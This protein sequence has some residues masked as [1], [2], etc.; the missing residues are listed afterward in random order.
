MNSSFKFD[1]LKA[2]FNSSF[3]SNCLGV[4]IF[5]GVRLPNFLAFLL[6][7]GDL[8]DDLADV[9]FDL[10]CLLKKS[11]KQSLTLVASESFFF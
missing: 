9:L 5:L 4:A 7:P 6:W 1:L 11:S 3:P 8:R 10:D 2:Y